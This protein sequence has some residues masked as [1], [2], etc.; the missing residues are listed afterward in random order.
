MA[1]ITTSGGLKSFVESIVNAPTVTLKRTR[2]VGIREKNYS[3]HAVR[4]LA[5]AVGW[6]AVPFIQRL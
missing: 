3:D 1:L 4:F 5:Y 2:G 6:L